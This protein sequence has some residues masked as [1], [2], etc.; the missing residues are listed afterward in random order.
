MYLRTAGNH[1]PYITEKKK[2]IILGS[3]FFFA[4][5]HNV[6]S[7]ILGSTSFLN[8]NAEKRKSFSKC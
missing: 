3:T 8:L 6:Y 5:K 7:Y 4:A 1:F 2:Y